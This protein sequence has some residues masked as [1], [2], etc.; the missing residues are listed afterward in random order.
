M[1]VLVS[2]ASGMIG[3]ELVRQLTS[4]GHEV[5]RLVRGEPHGADEFAW[6]PATRTIDD[7]ALDGVD[8]VVNLSG[9]SL[10]RLPWTRSH[11]R[12]ILSSRIDTTG[13]LADAL[14]RREQ[15][16]AVLINGS[17]VGFYG[18]RPGQTLTEQSPK[19]SGFLSDVVEAWEAAAHLA[20]ETT[21]VVTLRTG[22]VVGPGGAMK[23][24]LPIA[25]LGL[26]GPIGGGRQYWP[27]VSLHDEAAA[28]VHLLTSSL[29]GPVNVAGPEPATAGEVV[30][31]LAHALHRPSAVPVPRFAIELAL[32][33]AGR[34]ML[35]SSQR[36]VPQRLLDDGFV[37]RDR[38]VSEAIQ[39]LVQQNEEAA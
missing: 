36:V 33:D 24:L 14:R 4:G 16:P 34:E 28:I 22:V 18:D 9:A 1:R 35:L 38:T 5:R 27:W 37:F 7:R 32:R 29:S 17:A 15:P 11:R 20:P 19:G 12:R 25:K 13:T 39:A 26:A 2:G 3:T 10:A 30:A 6:A 8:A 31:A 21:R 23:P